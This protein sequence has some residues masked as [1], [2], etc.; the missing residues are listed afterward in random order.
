[1]YIFLIFFFSITVLSLFTKGIMVMPIERTLTN[2]LFV[3][4]T[5]VIFYFINKPKQDDN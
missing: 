2:L 3:I 1:M 4:I 5:F